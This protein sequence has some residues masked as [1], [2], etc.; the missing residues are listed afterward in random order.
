MTSF[1]LGI[2]GLSGSGKTALA[3][4]LKKFFAKKA[5]ILHLDNYQRFGE[6]LPVVEG[7]KNWDHPKAINWDKLI[8]DLIS[9]KED[10]TIVVESRDQKKLRATEKAKRTLFKPSP[11]IIVEGYLL[12][13]KAA[14]RKL[15]DFLV[16]LEASDETCIKRRTK[17]KNDDYLSKIL[18]PMSRRYILPTKRFANLVLNT[19]QSSIEDCCQ[20]IIRHLRRERQGGLLS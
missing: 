11:I 10:K 6:E 8:V 19:E 20:E 2:A 17:F 7:L 13:Y 16:F 3:K 5:S 15:L 1:L 14:V 9:L 4:E 12:F 18:L